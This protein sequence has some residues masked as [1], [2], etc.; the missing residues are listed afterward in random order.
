MGQGIKKRFHRL[1]GQGPSA[2]IR[3]GTAHHD[4]Q[5]FLPAVFE[6]MIDRVEGGLGVEGV[7]NGFNQ[8]YIHPAVHQ[9]PNL[10]GI[11]LHQFCEI[12]RTVP[13]VVHIRTDARRLV[14]RTDGTGYKARLGR[15]HRRYLIG[16]IAGNAGRGDIQF[17]TQF[18]HAVIGHGNALSIEGIGLQDIRP[19]LQVIAM[20]LGDDI[21]AG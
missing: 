3:N 20:D 19:R 8:E 1:T 14:G 9:A 18:F 15:I 13:G 12:H 6:K 21:R 10:L 7:K 11:R 5:G 16:L 2:V 17:V 4:R